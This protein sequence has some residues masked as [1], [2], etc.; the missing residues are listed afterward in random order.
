MP[1]RFE[2]CTYLRSE[3]MKKYIFQPPYEASCLQH[4]GIWRAFPLRQLNSR[5]R[6]GYPFGLVK[7]PG[8]TLICGGMLGCSNSIKVSVIRLW[9]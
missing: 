1:R 9:I 4:C 8:E 6:L 5:A 7:E 2:S 3:W